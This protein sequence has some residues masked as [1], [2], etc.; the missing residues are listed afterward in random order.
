VRGALYLF[1]ALALFFYSVILHSNSWI[2]LGVVTLTISIFIFFSHTAH[3]Q[4]GSV[5]ITKKWLLTPSFFVAALSFLMVFA[6]P[7]VNIKLFEVFNI[8]PVQEVRPSWAGTYQVSRGLFAESGNNAVFGVG[9]NRFFIPWQKY[10]PSEVNYTPWWG[11]DFNEGIGTIPSS[12]VSAGILGF[13]AWILFL[14]AFF[15]SGLFAFKKNFRHMDEI[16]QYVSAASFIAASYCWIAIFL[17]AVGAVP[18]VFAFIF[19]GLFLG[20]LSAS[21]LP[22]VREYNYLQNPQKGFIVVAILLLL[23]CISG[24]LGY[25]SIQR[26]RSFLAYRSA[27]IAEGSGN[28]EKADLEFKK[29]ILLAE[30][31]AYY[32][33]FSTLNSYRAQQLISR[34]DLS[35]DDLRTQ[36]GMNFQTSIDSAQKAI[37]IDDANYLNWITLGN[38]YSLLISLN[39]KDVSEDA[40]VRT[41]NA[42]EEAAKRNPFNPQIPYLLANAAVSKSRPDEA[43]SYAKRALALKSDYSDALILLSQIEEN[44]GNP[45]AALAVLE[46]S[47]AFNSSDPA[48][49]FLLGYLRYKNGAYETAVPAF[50]KAIR[51]I[52]D[53]S[54]AKYF[55]G[56]SYFEIG[57][58]SDAIKEF[59][60]IERLN[61][62]RTDIVQIINNLY[63]GYAPLSSS[64]SRDTFSSGIASTTDQE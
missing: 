30:S 48:V 19:T 35:A 16:M 26:T 12:L 4:T 47:F 59:K 10:R 11:V 5:S 39:I 2:I 21:G 62:G 43:I 33:S 34:T 55:L 42:Y 13:S 3:A 20:T 8:P 52:P 53:Y 46:E 1:L 7:A 61:P 31:D 58:A 14:V 22:Q 28:L 51:I 38:A 24:G 60:D 49:L 57:R 27:L 44:R 54:N 40:Y 63:G 25:I 17:N 37:A 23:L 50:E 15:F 6:G 41:K 9:P 32:R 18:F 36:F 56:L 29:A 45:K 64:D